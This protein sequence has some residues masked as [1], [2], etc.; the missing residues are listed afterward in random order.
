MPQFTI[1][2]QFLVPIYRSHATYEAAT[3]AEALRMAFEDDNWDAS[4]TDYDS[5]RETEITGAW[6]GEEAHVGSN[7]LTANRREEDVDAL[8]SSA[9]ES[10]EET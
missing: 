1:E 5:C 10:S 3:P 2:S 4:K 7:L 6:E 8:A 9:I